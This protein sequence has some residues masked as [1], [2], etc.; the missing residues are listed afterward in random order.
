MPFLSPIHSRFGQH[1]GQCEEA[2][3]VFANF[4]T[5]GSLLLVLV[6]LP[7][8]LFFVVKVVQVDIGGTTTSVLSI[9]FL[10]NLITDS[11]IW[12]FTNYGLD[13]F[14]GLGRIIWWYIIYV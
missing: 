14:E 2:P 4:I 5:L 3:G 6:S 12:P 7:L 1:Q 13:P 10:F 8:S 11:Q 9:W